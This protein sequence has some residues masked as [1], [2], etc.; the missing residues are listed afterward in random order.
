M[1]LISCFLARELL[2]KAV[3]GEKNLVGLTSEGKNGK[4]AV[5]SNVRD[6]IRGKC[7]SLIILRG[8]P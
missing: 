4:N 6:A 3:N 8:R 1:R 7:V 5:P 2:L